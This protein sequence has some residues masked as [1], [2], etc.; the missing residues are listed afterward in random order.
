M[1]RMLSFC[2][3]DKQLER[4]L[5]T[6][7]QQSHH[8][9]HISTATSVYSDACTC[10]YL[11]AC[12]ST[13]PSTGETDSLAAPVP[14][15]RLPVLLQAC[16]PAC[17][18]AC[19]LESNIPLILPLPL[20]P[21]LLLL[22]SPSFSPPPSP[23]LA[24]AGAAGAFAPQRWHRR[25]GGGRGAGRRAGA[26]SGGA[27]PRSGRRLTGTSDGPRIKKT[28]WREDSCTSVYSGERKHARAGVRAGMWRCTSLRSGRFFVSNR[29]RP[30]V[31]RG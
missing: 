5:H 17:L 4:A 16:P 1:G 10:A 30:I 28:G 19:L 12:M 20:P 6:D 13:H 18:P 21:T 3:V 9:T 14:R 31:P 11:P 24:A 7:E 2:A 29:F 22:V 23:S 8:P 15:A 25:I 26:A 27:G